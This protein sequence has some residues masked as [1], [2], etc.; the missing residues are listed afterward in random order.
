MGELRVYR[1]RRHR[2]TGGGWD[3]TSERRQ[4]SAQGVEA[5]RADGIGGGTRG[6]GAK[7]EA[8]VAL[9]PIFTFFNPRLTHSHSLNATLE[10]QKATNFYL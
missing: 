1:C 10:I 7:E 4:G 8:P 3:T 6:E 5:D 2:R 9:G